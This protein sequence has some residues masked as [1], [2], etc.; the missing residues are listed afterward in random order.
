MLRLAFVFFVFAVIVGVLG[1]GEAAAAATDVA[2][3]LFVLF[4]ALL[5]FDLLAR[6][7]RRR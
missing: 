2:K 7:T 4:P 6:M 3:L 1:F 5:V